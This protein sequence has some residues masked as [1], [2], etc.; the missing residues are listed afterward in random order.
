MEGSRVLGGMVVRLRE[1]AG[2][3]CGELRR[4]D[5]SMHGWG[6]WLD[7]AVGA[8]DGMDQV[9]LGCTASTYRRED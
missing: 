8:W 3:V 7:M 9:N 6:H 1:T 5:W 4:C 2:L